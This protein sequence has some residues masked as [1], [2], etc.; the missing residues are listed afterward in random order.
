MRVCVSVRVCASMHVDV[1]ACLRVCVCG[2]GVRVQEVVVRRGLHDRR[3]LDRV[4]GARRAAQVSLLKVAD[5]AALSTGMP[6]ALVLRCVRCYGPISCVAQ[7][8]EKLRTGTRVC[9]RMRVCVC[10]RVCAYACLCMCAC[11]CV[12][13]CVFVCVRRLMR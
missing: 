3:G 7:W 6:C 12:C 8:V 4:A 2:C 1:C 10:V 9:V 13:V 5:T 11:V